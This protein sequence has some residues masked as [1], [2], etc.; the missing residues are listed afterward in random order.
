MESIALAKANRQN[1]QK[2]WQVKFSYALGT[3]LRKAAQRRKSIARVVRPWR[4]KPTDR[5]PINDPQPRSGDSTIATPR[6]SAKPPPVES[7]C[8][9]A[10][11]RKPQ[12]QH[13]RGI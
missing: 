8:C 10:T 11:S 6:T 9:D 7:E 3:S 1:T 12:Q 5:T 2:D 4:R 13:T